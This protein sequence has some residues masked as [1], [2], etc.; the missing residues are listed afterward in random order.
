ML[1]MV[2]YSKIDIE[3]TT[4]KKYNIKIK[5]CGMKRSKSK[6]IQQLLDELQSS[7]DFVLEFENKTNN[8]IICNLTRESKG[9]YKLELLDKQTDSVQPTNG[10]LM[11]SDSK[12]S[13]DFNTDN[14]DCFDIHLGDELKSNK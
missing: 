8:H 13:L 6:V 14:N 5:R 1:E 7:E 2:N 4:N 11:D 10:D 9:R 3:F 12:L